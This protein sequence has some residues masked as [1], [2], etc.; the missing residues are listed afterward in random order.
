VEPWITRGNA[1]TL[2]RET[3]TIPD[4][5]RFLRRAL[6][7]PLRSPRGVSRIIPGPCNSWPRQLELELPTLAAAESRGTRGDAGGNPPR[8]GALYRVSLIARHARPAWRWNYAF[9][10]HRLRN[11][12][13]PPPLRHPPRRAALL[14]SRSRTAD[15][16]VARAGLKRTTR[17]S[18]N[19]PLGQ[20]RSRISRTTRLTAFPPP[21]WRRRTLV[22]S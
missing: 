3:E 4:A 15:E 5:H 19:A 17:A 11:S 20:Y 7:G 21:P 16:I 13:C 8:F 12:T 18:S 22:S 1:A 6:R 14:I 2:S 10:V 9:R